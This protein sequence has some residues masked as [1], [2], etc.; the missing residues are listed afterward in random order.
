MSPIV[1][2]LVAHLLGDWVLQTDW[3]AAKKMTNWWAMLEHLLTYHIALMLALA[4]STASAPIAWM[5][6]GISFVTHGF[7]DRRWPV[8][9]LM[10]HTGSQPFSRTWGVI[11]VDQALHLSILLLCIGWS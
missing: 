10:E 5:T 1:A 6:V 11:A 9:W 7:L 3:A 4:L 2:V 8:V